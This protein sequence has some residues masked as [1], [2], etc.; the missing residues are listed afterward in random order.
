M[1]FRSAPLLRDKVTHWAKS[2]RIGE[3]E[4]KT[5]RSA[6]NK[7]PDRSG[8]TLL[9]WRRLVV[10]RRFMPGDLMPLYVTIRQRR[11]GHSPERIDGM[12][13][14]ER[15]EG[16]FQRRVAKRAAKKSASCASF[17]DYDAVFSYAHLY[18][19]YQKCRRG[20]AWKASTQK[21]ITQAP[22]NV[23]LTQEK[24]QQGKFRSS[25]FH[26]FDLYERGKARHIKSVT[27]TE[28]VVQRCLCDYAL[29]PM[30]TR[31]F[32]YDNGASMERKGYHFA[33]RRLCQHLRE[34][35]RKHR[36][37][38]YILLFDFS[39]F[40][41]NVSHRI[42]KDILHKEFTD[43][44]I[45]LLTQH[46]IEMF[47]ERGLG[48][49]S[50]IS[51]VFALASANRLDHYVK[52]VCRIRGYGRYMDDGYLIHESKDYLQQC[53]EGIKAVCRELEIEL[54]EKKTQIVKIS[55]G[56]TFLKTRF[57]VTDTGKILRKIHKRSV[58]RQRRKL[59]KFVLLCEA[60]KM[61]HEDVYTSWQSWKAY[62]QNFS[63]WRTIRSLGRLY[64]DLF[65]R[66]IPPPEPAQ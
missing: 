50:Q 25:G 47:G 13:S 51:Q 63:A 15:R 49:G 54:N 27:I 55:H 44:R 22:L 52:E 23:H 2:V 24:L 21:Y 61:S 43:N 39:K 48:L 37:D 26:E 7:A 45:I 16:R 10:M 57:F 64:D 14:E 12:T 19:A 36:G 58:T 40:F 17:D 28:R 20:V 30:L 1:G 53:L 41:D 11:R 65:I 33:I 35:Y 59:K 8:R 31:T 18:R 60:G 42:C 38:G 46:F 4:N 5:L 62:A 29:V 56:F 6:V 32:V 66:G 34:N 3:K 9:A